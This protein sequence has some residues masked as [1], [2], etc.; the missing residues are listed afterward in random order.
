MFGAGIAVDFIM[1]V[2]LDMSQDWYFYVAMS[3]IGFIV[4]LH[5]VKLSQLSSIFSTGRG[6]ILYDMNVA[7]LICFG[8][9]ALPNIYSSLVT[10]NGYA[11]GRNSFLYIYPLLELAMEIVTN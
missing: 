3:I 9:F 7:F 11:D 5:S 6:L 4:T 2:I 8:Y 10:H 1:V